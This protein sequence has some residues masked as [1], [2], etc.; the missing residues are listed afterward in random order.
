MARS[1]FSRSFVVRFACVDVH[2]SALK[3]GVA[4]EDIEHAVRNAMAVDEL[5]G[6]L[7]LYLG[8]GSAGSLLEIVTL[9]EQG[10][11]ETMIHAMGMR[12]KY[13]RL[14]PGG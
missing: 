4:A 5:D 12:P 1:A 10:G 7:R 6:D 9:G 14:L 13:R 11:G 8:P 3:H 2:R